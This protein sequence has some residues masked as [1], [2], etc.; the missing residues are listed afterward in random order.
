[1]ELNIFKQTSGDKRLMWNS[2]SHKNKRTKV[3]LTER[4]AY[5]YAVKMQH[6]NPNQELLIRL[7]L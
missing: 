7:C 6:K 4:Y 5:L 2:S 1:M 3:Q